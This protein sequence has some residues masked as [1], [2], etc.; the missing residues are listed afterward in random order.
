MK[1][2][3]V[4]AVL[5][6]AVTAAGA[7]CPAGCNK[8]PSAQHTKH[9]YTHKVTVI[10]PTCTE[11]GY[12]LH[13]CSCGD[14]YKDNEKPAKGHTEVEVKGKDATCTQ[15]G[16]TDGK[17]CSVCNTVTVEQTVI[18]A[19]HKYVNGKCT[20]CGE[21][22]PNVT[23]TESL[24][25]EEIKDGETVVAYSVSGISDENV[26]DIVIPPE[27]GGLPVTKIKNEAFYDKEKIKNVSIPD[28]VEEIGE[29]AFYWCLEL[30][31]VSIGKGLKTIG[32]Y[33]FGG[34]FK[35][36]SMEIDRENTVLRSEGNCIMDIA[37]M[38]V[39]DGCTTSVIPDTAKA[40]GQN[41]FAYH[42]VPETLTFPASVEKIDRNAFRY[43]YNLKNLTIPSTVK[44][45]A[46]YAFYH[47]EDLNYVDMNGAETEMFSFGSCYNLW[48]MTVGENV[49]YLKSSS[50]S[51]CWRLID[52]YNKST[53]PL[54]TKTENNYYSID[55][56]RN[57]YKDEINKGEVTDVDGYKFYTYKNADGQNEFYLLGYYGTDTELTLPAPS[58]INFAGKTV[59]SYKLNFNA[60]RGLK[61]ITSLVIPDGVTEIGADSM[62]ATSALKSVT[63]GKDVKNILTRAF[64]GATALQEIT[65][66]ENVEYVEL[67]AF[68]NI[69]LTTVYWN[70]VDCNCNIDTSYDS[71]PN[72]TANNR[73]F[74]GCD[75]LA[76]VII[77]NKV[78]K[79]PIALFRSLPALKTVTIPASVTFIGE[80]A[81]YACEN[82]TSVN[83][84]DKSKSWKVSVDAAGEGSSSYPVQTVT[85][86][87]ISDGTAAAKLFTNGIYDNPKGYQFFYWFK[88]S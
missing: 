73:V 54:V 38:T 78:K 30:E 3:T 77:G 52:V 45:V 37:T 74:K 56:A 43:A 82:L 26:S 61:D 70:A 35:L 9:D 12:T 44:T 86:A 67:N 57:V 33:A 29:Q 46:G 42:A 16:L 58:E 47:C 27:H 13:E 62:R 71:A 24:T 10:D 6:C 5:L 83:F 28:S 80:C 65:V 63:I 14:S 66:P 4:T 88:Q 39:I 21:K 19:R 60:L 20:V 50:V 18:K 34:C 25:Y 59:E 36:S 81:F 17:K 75:K 55:Y 23:F 85:S 49:T 68:A 15:D 76:N 1:K 72:I 2:R 51:E 79:I 84:E 53:L 69:N 64:N 32:T 41:A 7:I 8:R 31:N 87:Q 11:E 40:I 48:H 22:D